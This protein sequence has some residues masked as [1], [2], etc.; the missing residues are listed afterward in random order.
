MKR[1]KP[2]ILITFTT[3]LALLLSVSGG[4]IVG[5]KASAANQNQND[6]RADKVARHLR[7]RASRTSGNDENVSVVVQF[8]GPMSGRLNSLLN[9][10]GIRHKRHFENLNASS[11]EL[12]ASVVDELS[13]LNEVA[14][15][16]EDDE[17]MPLGHVS[18][19]TGADDVRTQA[20]ASG[21]SCS[22]DG[23]GM[24]IAIL[25]SGIYAAHKSISSRLVFSKDFT[26]ENRVD[27]PYGHGTHVA[28]AA[29][30]NG[31]LYNGSYAGIAPNANLIN[32][33][34][35][36]SQG[37]STTSTVLS[38]LEWVYVNRA[39]YNIRVVNM[40]L[41]APALS[42]Y[43]NDP[44]CLAVRKLV[45]A[46]VVVV[47]AAGNEGKDAF[48]R[49]QY[50]GIHAPG[51]EP[52]AITVGASNSLGTNGRGDDSITSY[53]SRGPTRSFW[54]ERKLS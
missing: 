26:G 18:S 23:T 39:A 20:N 42:S 7:Q 41:G 21:V 43:K 1:T 5:T 22:L 32:L 35:L 24:G 13:S 34:V 19:T 27:D 38:A 15:V 44:L 37:R 31:T 12:P 53:S 40:S 51:N 14:F 49:K 2:S 6:K 30:G 11:I 4:G 33:R 45:N 10:N 54:A 29:A 52:S 36:N 46:G 47:T 9:R 16:S 50:G 8:N 3:C 28:A 17:V 25:D 48:G